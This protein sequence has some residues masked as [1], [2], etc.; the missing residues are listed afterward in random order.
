MTHP[1]A[2]NTYVNWDFESIWQADEDASINDGYPYTFDFDLPELPEYTV[3]FT[4]SDMEGNP[5]DDARISLGSLTNPLG[6]YAFVI[7][8]GA[9]PWQVTA[10]GYLPE[11]GSITV[12]DQNEP[13]MWC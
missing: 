3:S 1:H 2:S 12:T 11:M 4:V 5:I 7:N 6:E 9:F 8:P 13:Y 10:Q